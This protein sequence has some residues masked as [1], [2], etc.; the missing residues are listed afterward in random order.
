MICVNN[1]LFYYT[2]TKTH[3]HTYILRPISATGQTAGT[4]SS[5]IKLRVC[6]CVC[7]CVR[8][9]DITVC[10]L[11]VLVFRFSAFLDRRNQTSEEGERTE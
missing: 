11:S 6:V 5:P 8:V 1:Y 2:H 4:I 3:T 10:D 7:V 9:C